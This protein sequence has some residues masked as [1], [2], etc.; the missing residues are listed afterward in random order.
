VQWEQETC[1]LRKALK[2]H[3]VGF[4]LT[5][6]TSLDDEIPS[7]TLQPFVTAKLSSKEQR[8]AFKNPPLTTN[9][10]V[11]LAVSQQ[12]P[13]HIRS[14]AA[15]TQALNSFFAAEL[16]PPSVSYRPGGITSCFPA[17]KPSSLAQASNRTT[18]R[19]STSPPSPHMGG[20]RG[21]IPFLSGPTYSPRSHQPL[22]NCN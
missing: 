6:I 5:S 11:H 21:H 20:T 22:A 13:V 8:R 3:R 14:F 12:G 7:H 19:A 4:D 16:Q 17:N 9:Y 18:R 10:I 2:Q 15:G 1:T